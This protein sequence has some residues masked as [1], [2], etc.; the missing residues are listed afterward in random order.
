M[1][2]EMKNVEFE[3]GQ[4][5]DIVSEN[6]E[7]MKELFP[8]AFSEGG[9]NFETLRQLLGDASALDEG[10]E[11]YGLNWHG[12][13]K[14]RQIALTPSTGTL[15]PCPDESVDWDTTQNLFVEGDNLEVLKL[16]QKSYANKVKVIYID[17]PYNTGEEFIYPDKFQE[18]LDTY[19]K[20]TGQVDDEG[21]KFSSNTESIGRKH[22]NWLRMM[23][24]R[25]FLAKNLL[26]S[27]GVIFIS[28][29]DNEC[30]NLKTICDEVF[31]GENYI[32][33]I[34]INM[35]NIA[36]ASGGGQDKKLKKNVEYLHVYSKNYSEFNPFEN[37]FDL[38]PIPE[39][40]ERYKEEDKSW[41][42]TS[43]LVDDGEKAYAAS[44]VD[45]DG[46]EIKI[47]V[48]KNPSIMSVSQ[49]AKSEGIS[50]S[51]V[52]KI[53][54]KRIFQTQMPQSS[55][56]PRVMK[57]IKELDIDG[58]FFSIEY[59]PR[60]GKNKGVLYE[61][62]YK[63]ENFRLLAW[64]GDVSEEIDGVLYKKEMKGTYWDYVNETKNLSKEGRMS[65]PNG[66]KPVAMLRQILQM[67]VEKDCIVL[68]F[69]AGSASMAQAVMVQNAEDQGSRRYILVQLPEKCDEKSDF[70]KAGFENIA[71]IARERIIRSGE[72]IIKEN[73]IFQHDIGFKYFKLS[74]SNIRAWNPERADLEESLLSHEEHLVEG[75]TE[76][77][78]LYELLLKRGVDLAVPIESREMAGKNIYS[79]GYGVLFACLDESITKDQV[80]DIAQAIITWYGEL[81][82]SSDTHV[83]FR[84]SAFRDDV[85]KTNMAAILEQN[86]I[87]HVR[88]L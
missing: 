86:G 75:R 64:L 70:A 27:D 80:E 25:L 51:D 48:R 22:T 38:I 41:K 52:Y 46:N 2:N 66:K 18:N 87:T 13:K 4:S 77:D 12:K 23:Y 36:G 5:A 69:F 60:S 58:D 88:S 55:I 68:D 56:R 45:G 40:V 7:K 26:S 34:S 19:L 17:P 81:A 79:I 44:T 72:D 20:Y 32:N 42:Y 61:Q 82:P 85:S 73:S 21:M 6:I 30:A 35:K 71:K 84:D 43:V 39:L 29:D 78:I 50:E 33:T 57:K 28:I 47:Y 3:D 76:Q 24:P 74:A 14:A 63:G 37:V 8:D 31:G 59:V 15:L 16:L 53:Y 9:V 65:F 83:F 54:A 1:G 11:K 49:L 10:E 62:F 67:Q